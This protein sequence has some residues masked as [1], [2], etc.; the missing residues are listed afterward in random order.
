MSGISK[1]ESIA[2][3][4]HEANRK[5][6]ESI[7]D[8]SQVAWKDAPKWQ[9]ESA[10]KGV[11]FF[12]HNPK[13]TPEMMHENW[14]AQ[15]IAE[16]WVYGETKDVEKKTHPCLVPYDKLPEEQKKKDEIF[17]SIIKSMTKKQDDVKLPTFY[18]VKSVSANGRWRSGIHFTE[19][20]SVLDES[21]MTEDIREDQMLKID[22]MSS[23]EASEYIKKHPE[24][25]E[26]TE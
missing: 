22:K 25:F 11:E 23:K 19:R 18:R 26:I 9:K 1:I 13:L 12:L 6:C 14:M 16:G 7:G 17:I 24:E 4:C 10:I 3:A 2:K 5:Y 21:E 20:W 15:K 8:T